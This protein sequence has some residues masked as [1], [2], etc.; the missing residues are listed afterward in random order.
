MSL[1]KLRSAVEQA[2]TLAA[3]IERLQQVRA[4][5]PPGTD[6]RI[7]PDSAAKEFAIVPAAVARQVMAEEIDRLQTRLVNILAAINAAGN[8]LP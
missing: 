6:A 3:R 7:G 8:S 4:L 2:D 1:A 5:I